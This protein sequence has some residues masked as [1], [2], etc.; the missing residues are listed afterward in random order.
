MIS[1]SVFFYF[2]SAFFH[3]LFRISSPESLAFRSF[4]GRSFRIPQKDERST[5]FVLFVFKDTLKQI[6]SAKADEGNTVPGAAI[7]DLHRASFELRKSYIKSFEPHSEITNGFFKNE[8]L[9]VSYGGGRK[10]WDT[11]LFIWVY[12]L[13]FPFALLSTNKGVVILIAKELIE[14]IQLL[15]GIR[16]G[17]VRELFF[18]CIYEKDANFIGLALNKRGIR[19]SKITS[20]VPMA[21][22]N[23]KVIAD[24][25]CICFAYQYEELAK[26]AA[27]Q[28]HKKVE[29]W[30]PERSHLVKQIYSNREKVSAELKNSKKKIGFYS[31]GGWIRKKLGHLEQGTN[32]VENE[33][34]VLNVLCDQCAA[35]GGKLLVF[36]HP[37]EKAILHMDDTK[38]HYDAMLKNIEY[39]FANLEAGT[40][41]L[42]HKVDLAVSFT[43]TVVFERIY[44]GFKTL[45][46]PIG[47]TN[48]PLPGSAINGICADSQV[49]LKLKLKNAMEQ[50][51]EEFFKN[52][53]LSTYTNYNWN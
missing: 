12:F 19:S 51:T 24:R 18:F 25:L 13:L 45:I 43:S 14:T 33:S 39:E 42:F 27:G 31:T 34:L 36:L 21:V 53:G 50:S 26:F 44:F 23:S 52:N 17:K 32:I 40:S 10:I 30:G 8:L 5:R 38:A 49:D 6:W 9:N 2:I 35:T 16:K 11:L 7:Y 37:R 15:R 41:E 4:L 46:M 29:L 48:F 1:L 22:W 20:E 47:F 28:Y 3:H